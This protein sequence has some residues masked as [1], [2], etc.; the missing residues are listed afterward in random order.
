MV[1]LHFLGGNGKIHSQTV[2]E[3]ATRALNFEMLKLNPLP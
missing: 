2:H 3:K 1:Q